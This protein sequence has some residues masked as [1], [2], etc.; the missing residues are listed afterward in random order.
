MDCKF[1][2][3]NHFIF[4]IISVPL[5]TNELHQNALLP[6]VMDCKFGRSNYF[7]FNIISIPLITNEL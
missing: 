4:N 2:R 6:N 1:G 5:I 3:S 7:I